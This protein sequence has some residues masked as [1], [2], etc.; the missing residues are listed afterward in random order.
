MRITNPSICILALLL[1]SC[2]TRSPQIS[3]MTTLPAKYGEVTKLR[4]IAVLPFEGPQG[5]EIA[6]EI[7]SQ[8]VS[9]RFDETPY[10][11]VIERAR[12]DRVLSELKLSN[13]A[14]VD[15]KT[16]VKIGRLLGVQAM[17]MGT[18][19]QPKVS[20]SHFTESRSQCSHYV[21]KYNKKGKPYEACGGTTT[22]SINCTRRT[23]E[24]TIIPRVV[25]VETGRI[26][27]S[28]TVSEPKQEAACSDRG[29]VSSSN[30]MIDNA[31]RQSLSTFRKHVAPHQATVTIMLMEE[32]EG[33]NSAAAA[34]FENGLEYAKARRVDRAC[35]LWNEALGI[36]P[37]AVALVYSR[38]LCEELAG[39]YQKALASYRSADRI[40][41]KP[42]AAI[43]AALNRVQKQID[44]DA[45]LAK[46]MQPSK[47]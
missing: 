13:S 23:A 43:S 20:D 11:T 7:E 2:A 1:T 22:Y 46:Q 34:K 42:H 44:D 41:N 31:R 32:R 6:S 30:E 14:L 35:E 4:R 10:F 19:R 29:S 16:A 3:T 15:N 40:L 27:Y 5:R 37:N 45:K 12:I 21:T 24:F 28:A 38:G 25:E 26:I 9:A 17:Y 47:R 36:S 33:M 18:A 8:L 39:D